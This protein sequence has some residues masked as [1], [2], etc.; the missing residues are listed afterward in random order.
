[1]EGGTSRNRRLMATGL[2]FIERRGPAGPLNP[3]RKSYL[4]TEDRQIRLANAA[5]ISIPGTHFPLQIDLAILTMSS[6]LPP[7][8][9]L[10]LPEL[11]HVP[12][13]WGSLPELSGDVCLE[14]IRVF[15]ARLYGSR[16]RKNQKLLNGVKQVVEE[17]SS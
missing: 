11:Y 3:S 13:T 4:D 8:C 9:N 10:N 5:G 6:V 16:S 12:S 1:M 14:I 17:V 15:S 7:T 2:A